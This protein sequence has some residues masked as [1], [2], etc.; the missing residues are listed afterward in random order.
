MP[1]CFSGQKVK[2]QGHNALITGKIR[3]GNMNP[4]HNF[5]P[6]TPIVMQLH[7]QTPHESRICPTYFGVKRSKVK[8]TM[9]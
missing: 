3:Y 6:F 2:G 9:H 8:V 4:A 5:F 1:Y 7:T